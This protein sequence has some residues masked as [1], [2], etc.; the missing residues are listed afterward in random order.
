[1]KP[2]AG[3]VFAAFEPIWPVLL[4]ATIRSLVHQLIWEVRWSARSNRFVVMLDEIALHQYAEELRPI[5]EDS[6]R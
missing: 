5:H 3:E 2:E 4:P 6:P 1:M